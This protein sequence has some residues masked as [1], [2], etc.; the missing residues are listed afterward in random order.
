MKLGLIGENRPDVAGSILANLDFTR[1][2]LPDQLE[3][4]PQER[5]VLQLV[6]SGRTSK[7]IVLELRRTVETVRTHRRNLMAK[8]DIHKQTELVRFAL[9]EGLLSD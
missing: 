2:R 4:L 3:K 1:K 7:E 8:L 9:R 5:R 6:A